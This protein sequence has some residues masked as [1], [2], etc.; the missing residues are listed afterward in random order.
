MLCSGSFVMVS[1]LLPYLYLHGWHFTYIHP[2]AI[3]VDLDGP[4]TSAQ[5]SGNH[6][7]EMLHHSIRAP[8]HLQ[9]KGNRV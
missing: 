3:N 5:K 8:L 6:F 4:F 9:A 2:M 1:C 7:Q